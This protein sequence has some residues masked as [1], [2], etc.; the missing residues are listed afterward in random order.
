MREVV[1]IVQQRKID[2]AVCT[3]FFNH[4]FM[5]YFNSSLFEWENKEHQQWFIKFL[6]AKP[7][8]EN[9]SSHPTAQ[10]GYLLVHMLRW[11]ESDERFVHNVRFVCILLLNKILPIPLA[12]NLSKFVVSFFPKAIITNLEMYTLCLSFFWCITVLTQ[13]KSHHSQ[14][15]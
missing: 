3:S 9:P 10:Y 2:R 11:C 5:Y 1:L 14:L 6:D 7:F 4:L 8:L 15:L 13:N 12:T